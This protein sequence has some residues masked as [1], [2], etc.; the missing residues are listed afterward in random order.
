MTFLSLI[1][2]IKNESKSPRGHI[3]SLGA[4]ALPFSSANT[5][6]ISTFLLAVF[7]VKPDISL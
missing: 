3:L 2:T 6:K 7:I 5:H 4:S 1:F